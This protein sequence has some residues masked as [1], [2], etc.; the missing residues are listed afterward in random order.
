MFQ[1]AKLLVE[2]VYANTLTYEL[3][4]T[5][6]QTLRPHLPSADSFELLASVARVELRDKLHG[7]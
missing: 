1:Y 5:W 2:T 6:H 4:L 7:F 3:K